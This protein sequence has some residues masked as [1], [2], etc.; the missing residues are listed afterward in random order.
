M[1]KI[2]YLF[3]TLRMYKISIKNE[4]VENETNRN[5]INENVIKLYVN[6]PKSML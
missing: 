1:R 3:L 5:K 6:I 4:S 2:I